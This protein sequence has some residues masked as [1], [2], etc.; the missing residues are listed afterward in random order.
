MEELYRCADKMMEEYGN[1]TK[2]DDRVPGAVRIIGA[3]LMEMKP[4]LNKRVL[5]NR[6]SKNLMTRITRRPNI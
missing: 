3:L 2:F 6:Y 5:P 4:R 1:L